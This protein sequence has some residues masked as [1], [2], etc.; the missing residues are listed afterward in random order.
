M[1]SFCPL[2]FMTV[3]YGRLSVFGYK[4]RRRT[5]LWP[6]FGFRHRM[7]ERPRAIC[8]VV[9]ASTGVVGV[10]TRFLGCTGKDAVQPFI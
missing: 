9:T 8:R 1:F 3:A 10:H 6:V 2:P 4:G 7:L 5:L